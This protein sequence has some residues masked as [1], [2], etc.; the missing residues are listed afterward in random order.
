MADRLI[1]NLIPHSKPTIRKN[2]L[3]NTLNCM[4]TDYIGPGVFQAL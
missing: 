2:E 3:Q 4:I 1:N